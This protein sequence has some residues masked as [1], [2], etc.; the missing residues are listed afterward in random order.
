MRRA[1]LLTGVLVGALVGGL[2]SLP[3][4]ALSFLGSQLAGLPFIPF[5]VF[6]W[7]ARVLPGRL[8]IVTIETM[9]KVIRALNLGAT[10]TVAKRV[11]GGLGV[12]FFIGV[13]VVVGAIAALLIRR[14]PQHR[15]IAEARDAALAV[16][17]AAGFV[18]LIGLTVVEMSLNGTAGLQSM[19]LPAIL[20]LAWGCV[21]GLSLRAALDS[22][23]GAAN[24]ARAGVSADVAYKDIPVAV[25]P[26]EVARAETAS[27]EVAPTEAAPVVNRRAFLLRL[28]A[29]T[30]GL[31]VVAGGVAELLAAER[32]RAVVAAGPAVGA[33]AGQGT[34]VPDAT[35]TPSA[36]TGAVSTT[37]PSA[38]AA[39]TAGATSVAG[40]AGAALRDLIQPAPGTRPELTDNSK[41]YRID[42]N[43]FPP[44]VDEATW[45]VE[46]SGL[47]DKP[48]NLKLA[49]LKAFP[50]V[51]QAITM[52]C[53]SN[54]VG[55]DLIST[56]RWTGAR[57]VDVLQSLGIK[58]SAKELAIKAADGFY[59]SV[60]TQDMQDPRTLLVYAMNGESL[61]QAHGFPLR[62][63]IP[64]HYGMKQPKW[65]TSIE[66]ID[67]EGPGYWVDR[68]WSATAHPQIVSVIDRV[69][70]ALDANGKSPIGGIAWAGDRG[71]RKVEI[72]VDNGAWTE[73]L[74]RTPPLSGL[75]WIQWRYDWPVTPGRHTFQVRATDGKGTLQT[76]DPADTFPD[77]ATGYHSVIADF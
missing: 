67:H 5:D 46:V 66:A 13:C 38:A 62:I 76:P 8:I 73:T 56:S 70:I 18:V 29:G 42:I 40:A 51:T 63:Y 3:L 60:V 4:I 1:T 53:I 17:A 69:S 20:L 50:A 74:L 64:N 45:Q 14:Q 12:L 15:D 49:D 59:E 11:E 23:A 52:G 31:A 65:I 22:L 61:P 30:T 10:D 16:G 58:P 48:R 68:G 25:A 34:L 43:L 21:L 55:G 19:W 27:I 54:P 7:L 71:I 44:A 2:T 77:G 72:Q 33:A 75:T 28:A 37:V 47:F 35:M 39:P 26:M 36:L 6:D 41:F 9:V 57:L 24:V 32:G